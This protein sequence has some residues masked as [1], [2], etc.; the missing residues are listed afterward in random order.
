MSRN[1]G[2]S[3]FSRQLVSAGITALG[4]ASTALDLAFAHSPPIACS[5]SRAARLR[6]VADSPSG[7]SRSTLRFFGRIAGIMR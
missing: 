6:Q 4:T 7:A 2:C 3:G 5:Y 1:L